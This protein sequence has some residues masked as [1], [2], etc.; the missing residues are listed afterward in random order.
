MSSPEKAGGIRF[1]QEFE[2]AE[3]GRRK[4]YPVTARRWERMI[5][6]L[7]RAED[8]VPFYQSGA[9]ALVGVATSA[10]FAGLLLPSSVEESNQYVGVVCWNIFV[11]SFILAAGMFH[12]ART[13]KEDRRQ[14]RMQVV[15]DM[16]DIR[17][18]YG[19]LGEIGEV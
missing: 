14:L 17:E 15:E 7:E 10:F 4:I 18:E 11:V 3:P 16:K 19:P 13:H 9:W 1:N 5:E 12:F 8:H 6:R 2:I